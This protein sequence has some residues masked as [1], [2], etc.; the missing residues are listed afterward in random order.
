MHQI[1]FLPHLIAQTLAPTSRHQHKAV[2][3]LQSQEICQCGQVPRE[4]CL[5]WPVLNSRLEAQRNRQ[6][7]TCA[8]LIGGAGRLECKHDLQGCFDDLSLLG[9]EVPVAKDPFVGKVN[10]V[11]GSFTSSCRPGRACVMLWHSCW[12]LHVSLR[13]ACTNYDT[14]QVPDV[15]IRQ[16]DGPTDVPGPSECAALPTWIYWPHEGSQGLLPSTPISGCPCSILYQQH[17]W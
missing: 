1:A 10:Q 4:C 11:H 17:T 9:P 13:R 7:S 2:L 12:L 16:Q 5:V 14:L 15:L 3:F 8:M 6:P